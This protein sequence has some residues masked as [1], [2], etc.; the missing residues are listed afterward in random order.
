MR[1]WCEGRARNLIDWLCDEVVIGRNRPA[2]ECPR[3]AW[4]AVSQ[5]F[6]VE[7]LGCPKNQV[8]SDKL[9]GTLLADGM[10]ATDDAG[11]RRPRGRQHVRVHRGGPP[12]V[13]R[14]DPRARR[15][16]PRRC[17]TGRDRLHGRALRRRA[18]RG[19]ARG[20]PGRRVRRARARRSSA[21]LG[22]RTQAD[23]GR[24]RRRCPS[25]TCSTCRGRSRRARGPT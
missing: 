10:E 21:T 18:G 8:D 3:V 7:T 25:S 9:V 6:Y 14:H 20:R 4:L 17:P 11:A 23:P 1:S 19:A 2:Q 5:R 13:D 12:G 24:R 15:A 16:A 22:P